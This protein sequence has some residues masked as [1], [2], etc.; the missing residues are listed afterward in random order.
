MVG[1]PLIRRL[2]LATFFEGFHLASDRNGSEKS[3]P[4]QKPVSIQASEDDS[5]E[6]HARLY[7]AIMPLGI[8]VIPKE[9]LIRLGRKLKRIHGY[10]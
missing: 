3:I 2:K 5:V 10:L 7:G 1:G 6:K 4:S 9:P 8:L